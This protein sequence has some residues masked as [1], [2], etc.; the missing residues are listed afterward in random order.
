MRSDAV[1]SARR[2]RRA[3]QAP[4][5]DVAPL[6][7]TGL[8]QVARAV[9]GAEIVELVV[10]LRQFGD[11]RWLEPR[12][13]ERIVKHLNDRGRWAARAAPAAAYRKL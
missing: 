2:S 1:C 4:L 9:V 10:V 6:D 7:R 11:M 8:A 5:F 13:L 3:Q 12:P